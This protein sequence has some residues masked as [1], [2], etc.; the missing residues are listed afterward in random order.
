MLRFKKFTAVLFILLILTGS[1]AVRAAVYD[2]SGTLSVNAVFY[3]ADGKSADRLCVS[4]SDSI[5]ADIHL[6][7]DFPVGSMA[8]E[9]MYNS[10]MLEPDTQTFSQEDGYQLILNNSELGGELC[11]GKKNI[12]A[13]MDTDGIGSFFI[14][15]TKFKAQRYDDYNAFSVYFRVKQGAP[16]GSESQFTIIPGTVMNPENDILPTE[17]DY[18]I[19][20]DAVGKSSPLNW[21]DYIA[22]ADYYLTVESSSGTLL[23]SHTPSPFVVENSTESTCKDAGTYDEVVYCSV[24]GKELSRENK[25]KGLGEHVPLPAAKENET[26][27]SCTAGGRY[28]NVTRCGICGII[29]SSESVNTKALGHSFTH[30]S[31]NGD[32]TFGSDGTETAKCDRCTVTDTRTRSGSKLSEPYIITESSKTV[33]YRSIVTV[34]AKCDNLDGRYALAIYE[35]DTLRARGDNRYVS[36]GLGELR[37]GREF[38]V[39]IVDADGTPQKNAAGNEFRS[40]IKVNVNAGFFKKIIA[41]FKGLFRILPK[42]TVGP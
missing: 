29:L 16:E 10:D 12:P 37:S 27:A 15:I 9:F 34:T 30:Y 38:N 36:Y 42:V 35:G 19:N 39:R 18:V 32:A 40:G 17:A 4:D 13:G 26:P 14:K 22:A 31:Y 25:T 2:L 41:F 8:F 7:S 21:R 23:N 11:D 28:D 1:V 24:C 5:R 20:P 6:S 3:N 33:D